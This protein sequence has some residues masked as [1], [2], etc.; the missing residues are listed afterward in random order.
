MEERP[1]PSRHRSVDPRY[2]LRIEATT[3]AAETRGPSRHD[4]TANPNR[5]GV[6]LHLVGTLTQGTPVRVTLHLEGE[7]AL[8]C[9]GRVAWID[10]TRPSGTWS[11]GVAFDAESVEDLVANLAVEE[12]A[13]AKAHFDG[14]MPSRPRT[15]ALAGV[16]REGNAP[17][18]P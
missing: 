18:S 9:E 11:L 17:T 4:R 7:A 2:S 8:A 3:E 5:G 16:V 13:P 1:E 15:G 10:P 14:S 12:T 6:L